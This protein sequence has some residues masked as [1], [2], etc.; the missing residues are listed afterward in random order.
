MNVSGL[1]SGVADVQAGSYFACALTTSGGVKCW[2]QNTLGQ[3]GD[4]TN[5]NRTTPV[6]V[7]GLTTGVAK[8]SVGSD[9]ACALTTSGGVKCWGWNRDGQIG[10]GSNTDSNL[11]VDVVGLTMNASDISTNMYHACAVTSGGGVKCWGIN[12]NGELGNNSYTSS[13]VSVNVSGL[14]N[15][16]AKVSAGFTNT[17]AITTTGGLKCWGYNGMGQLGVGTENDYRNSPVDAVGLTSGVIN[18]KNNGYQTC[19]VTSSNE[20]KCFGLNNNGQLG[21]GTNITRSLP[22]NVIK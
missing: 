16:I 13:N 7:S 4:G 10:D 17:C 21:D 6:D 11:P 1:T 14:T 15:G 5:T 22:V 19:V 8:L 18:I 20:A 2:G 3:L 12:N 9:Y